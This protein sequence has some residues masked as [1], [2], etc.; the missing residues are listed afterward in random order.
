MKVRAIFMIG[1]VFVVFCG[2]VQVDAAALDVN[3]IDFPYTKATIDG[4]ETDVINL[5][6]AL[7]GA[8]EI[9]LISFEQ[10]GVPQIQWAP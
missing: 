6:T 5:S 3:V 4:D 7:V 2:L 8:A 10:T 1:M 9:P